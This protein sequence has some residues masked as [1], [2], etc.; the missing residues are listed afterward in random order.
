MFSSFGGGGGCKD[1]SGG[2]LNMG[3][4]ENWLDVWKE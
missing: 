4:E 3:L 2:V 1:C